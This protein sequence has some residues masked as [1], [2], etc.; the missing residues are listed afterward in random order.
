MVTEINKAKMSQPYY[1]KDGIE[2]LISDTDWLAE[3]Y[4][5]ALMQTYN[6]S[7]SKGS[8]DHISSMS[9]NYIDQDGV[10]K[11]SDYKSISTRLNNEFRFI[12]NK[13]R[14]GESVN[15]SYWT[16][17]KKPNIYES[18]EKQLLAQHPAQAVYA[19]N[20]SYAGSEVDLLGSRSNPVR[21][22]DN[23]ANNTY[24]SWRI[25]GNA[26]IEA[27]PVNNLILKSSFGINNNTN[28]IKVFEPAWDEHVRSNHISSL[29]V[30]ESKNMEWVWTNTASTI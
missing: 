6:L 12:D 9:L 2:L 1:S 22:I 16:Q 26:Y 17:H 18:I 20:G 28:H 29:Y 19:N 27:V 30:T 15:I 8:K 3:C 7:M 23:E 24:N 11:K 13:L 5:P 10:L 14:V 21:F 25:F 4:R